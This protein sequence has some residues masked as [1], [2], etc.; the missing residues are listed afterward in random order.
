MAPGT[1]YVSMGVVEVKDGQTVKIYARNDSQPE[2][3]DT[4]KPGTNKPGAS[5]QKGNDTVLLI[6]VVVAMV[7]LIAMV[8]VAILMFTKK[9]TG[10]KTV[11]KAPAKKIEKSDETK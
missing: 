5:T 11:K 7:V 10:K 1:D 6:V 4:G 2:P 3:E 8:T 9:P